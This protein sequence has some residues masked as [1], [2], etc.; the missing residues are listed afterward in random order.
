VTLSKYEYINKMLTEL[1]SDMNGLSKIPASGHLFNINPDATKLPESKAQLFLHLVAKVLYL[2]WCTRQDIQTTVAFL[3]TWVKE[4]DEDDYNKLTKVMKYIRGTR[5][6][7]LTIEPN[8]DPKWWVESTYVVHPD[9][10]SH[11]SVVISLG[12]RATYTNST[13]RKLISKNSM[14][15]EL[16]AIDDA[17]A[18]ILWTRHFLVAQGEYVPATY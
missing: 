12:K 1:P 13:K 14:E 5:E 15:A 6:H 10:R 8:A 11:T 18:Q 9:M 3:C 16:V 4:L 17:M 2:C 7:K